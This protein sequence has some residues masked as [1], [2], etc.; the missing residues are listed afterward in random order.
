[1]SEVRWALL[2]SLFVAVFLGS[3]PLLFRRRLKNR[4]ATVPPR[5]L[6]VKRQYSH[7]A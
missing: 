5:W 7:T 1:M 4:F 2:R 3:P 6:R